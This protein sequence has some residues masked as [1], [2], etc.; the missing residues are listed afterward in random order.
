M[1]NSFKNT[2]LLDE[3]LLPLTEISKKSKKM[4]PNRKDKAFLNRLLYNLKNDFHWKER[5]LG[6][7]SSSYYSFGL[8]NTF[9]LIAM[10]VS[11]QNI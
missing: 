11:L 7:K 1:E 4:V 3:K 8:K 5:K 9:P 2:F 10:K 6:I